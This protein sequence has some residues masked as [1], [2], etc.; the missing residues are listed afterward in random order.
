MKE[1]YILTKFQHISFVSDSADI[2]WFIRFKSF[3]EGRETLNGRQS[4]I[5][6]AWNQNQSI[7]KNHS[8]VYS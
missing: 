2:W 1:P 3:Y 7:I 4:K 8:S 5:R 6:S